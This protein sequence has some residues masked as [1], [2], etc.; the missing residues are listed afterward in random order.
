MRHKKSLHRRQLI[1]CSKS[2]QHVERQCLFSLRNK[3]QRST[4][5]ADQNICYFFIKRTNAASSWPKRIPYGS[6]RF[7]WSLKLRLKLCLITKLTVISNRLVCR[8]HFF[9]RVAFSNTST[10]ESIFD[11]KEEIGLKVR[12]QIYRIVAKHPRVVHV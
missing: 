10:F 8:V 6:K 1:A 12:T 2:W 7:L 3:G 4:R 5:S 11:L 9:V